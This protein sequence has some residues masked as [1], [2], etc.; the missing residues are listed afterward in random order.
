MDP[1]TSTIIKQ[2]AAI[3]GG[4]ALIG[5]ALAIAYGMYQLGKLQYAMQLNLLPPPL[6]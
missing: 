3:F 5:L 2:S 1:F 4:V 6:D